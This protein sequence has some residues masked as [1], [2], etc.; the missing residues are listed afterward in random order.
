MGTTADKVIRE[1]VSPNSRVTWTYQSTKDSNTS[2]VT[3]RLQGRIS[4]DQQWLDMASRTV[5]LENVPEQII[6]LI[7]QA[8]IEASSL[9]MGIAV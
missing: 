2:I 5:T 4:A 6:K 1:S 9:Q 8:A 7:N 3:L